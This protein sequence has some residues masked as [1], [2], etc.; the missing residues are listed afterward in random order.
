MMENPIKM[1]VSTF[2]MAQPRPLGA[3]WDRPGDRSDRGDRRPLGIM[4]FMTLNLQ[5]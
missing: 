5:L 1:D 3:S 2:P 4:E